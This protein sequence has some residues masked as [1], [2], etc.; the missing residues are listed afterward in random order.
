MLPARNLLLHSRFSNSVKVSLLELL[1][2][3]NILRVVS[4]AH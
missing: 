2:R 4:A 1:E 3:K